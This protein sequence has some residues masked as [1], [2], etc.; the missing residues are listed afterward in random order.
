MKKIILQQAFDELCDAIA[1]Y[2]EKQAGLGLRLKEEI[3]QHVSWIFDNSTVPQIRSGKYRRVNLNLG[4][5][6]LGSW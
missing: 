5:V 4:V 3:D 1:Y 6:L 2:E